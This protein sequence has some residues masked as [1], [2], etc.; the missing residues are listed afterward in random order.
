MNSR[1]CKNFPLEKL[2]VLIFSM[3]NLSRVLFEVLAEYCPDYLRSK[4][5]YFISKKLI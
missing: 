5:R 1:S 3:R 2:E 4:S